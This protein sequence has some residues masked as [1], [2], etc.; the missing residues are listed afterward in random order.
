MTRA[1][2]IKLL[3]A[4]IALLVSSSQ[5]YAFSLTT[6][7]TKHLGRQTADVKRF[8]KLLAN[9]DVA[10]LQE[11]NRP[12]SSLPML[13]EIAQEIEAQTG[14]KICYVISN[15]PT[16][17]TTNRYAFMWR[18]SRIRVYPS[19]HSN[20]RLTD[21]PEPD[22][23]EMTDIASASQITREPALAKF[24]SVKDRLAFIVAGVHL[25][26]TRRQP[27]EEVPPL[28]DSL[29]KIR[30]P[31]LV[32]GDFNLS[33]TNEA[34]TIAREYGFRASLTGINTSLKVDVRDYSMPYDNVWYRS[35]R[36]NRASRTD[37]FAV[38]SELTPQQ[39]RRSLSD[40][41]PVHTEWLA[42]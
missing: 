8:A 42:N 33:S 31:L 9:T 28:F 22:A 15:L 4:S 13:A 10:V 6:W 23:Y 20:A 32:A 25:V 38:F 40:H 26:P 36:R 14:E 24:Y 17:E 7:N 3:C 12:E 39:I 18:S 35:I 37:V 29:D 5:A 21:C 27:S 19:I 11:V 41:A 30:N 34:F 2:G 1:F 16:D